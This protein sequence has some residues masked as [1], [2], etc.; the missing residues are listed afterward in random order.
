MK[1][2]SGDLGEESVYE[3]FHVET[4]DP[5]EV[6]RT[7][8]ITFRTRSTWSNSPTARGSTPSRWTTGTWRTR[9]A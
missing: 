9:G 1:R 7:C 6:L 8:A 3:R 2:V 5:S 4:F